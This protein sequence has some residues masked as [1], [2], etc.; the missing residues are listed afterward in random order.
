ME[1]RFIKAGTEVRLASNGKTLF[2]YAAI[3]NQLSTDPALGFRE[4]IRPGAFARSI[5]T[6][7]D[8]QCLQ[9]HNPTMILGRTKS[10]TLRLAEDTRGLQFECDLPETTAGRD[11]RELCRRGD[12]SECS[13]G[14]VA[15]DQDWE[16]GY[17]EKAQRCVIRTLKD[18]DILD[19][20]VVGSPAYEGTSA[21]VRSL[22][23]G[24]VPERVA[25]EC[26]SRGIRVP[27][28][29][30]VVEVSDTREARKGLRNVVLG[31]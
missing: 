18:V 15:Q 26:R 21:N 20:S 19:V 24:A 27:T 5:R 4:K 23:V 10:G 9:E 22:F 11:V 3:F 17:D 8:V 29:S 25:V 28:L 16:D 14:F 31:L 1:K 6:K 30:E 7:A 2:G 12:L 13:F